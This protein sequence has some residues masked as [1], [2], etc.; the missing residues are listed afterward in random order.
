MVF[1][2]ADP[3]DR[4]VFNGFG[5]TCPAIDFQRLPVETAG[6]TLFGWAFSQCTMINAERRLAAEPHGVMPVNLKWNP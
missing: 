3:G 5:T 2:I 6:H 4:I 1:C